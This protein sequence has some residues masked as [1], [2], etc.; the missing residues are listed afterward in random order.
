MRIRPRLSYA[1]VMAT[2]A[3]VIA[4]TGSAYVA[5]ALEKNE[6]KSFHIKDGEVKTKDLDKGAT[7]SNARKVNGSIVKQISYKAPNNTPAPPNPFK[8]LFKI[9]GLTIGAHC[10]DN[11]DRVVLRAQTSVNGSILGIGAVHGKTYGGS[12]NTAFMFPGV[13]NEFNSDEPQF[14]ELDDTVTT[15]TYGNGPDSKPVV[16]ATFLA[17]QFAGG[18]NECKVVGTVI[19]G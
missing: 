16:T 17:N 9:N 14:A 13:A 18:D 4:L 7:I 15:L 11:D 3:V 12:D 19:S 1:N 2:V 10:S 6:V 8:K 5:F